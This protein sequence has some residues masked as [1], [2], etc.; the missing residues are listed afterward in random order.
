MVV[1]TVVLVQSCNRGK[2]ETSLPSLPAGEAPSTEGS[3][4]IGSDIITDVYLKPDPAGDPWELEKIK[5]FNGEPMFLNIIEKIN[6]DAI[7]VF[8]CIT[9]EVLTQKDIRKI[10]RETGSDISGIGKIQFTEDWYFNPSTNEII[11]KVKSVS[12]GYEL[13]RGDGLPPAY[14][15]YFQVKPE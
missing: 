9:G 13:K 4:K 6:R 5:G 12:L 1:L 11:K 2:K 7:K 8:D 3:I 15:P 14:L 10:L